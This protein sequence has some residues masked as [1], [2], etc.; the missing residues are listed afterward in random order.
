MFVVP[1]L[2]AQTL[3]NDL[4]VCEERELEF[5]DAVAKNDEQ[6]LSL[7]AN[8]R[9]MEVQTNKSSSYSQNLERRVLVRGVC[10]CVCMCVLVYSC[11]AWILRM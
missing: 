2:Q 3:E 10:T 9:S 8:T 4:E 11:Q 6:L 1:I 5:K 7:S